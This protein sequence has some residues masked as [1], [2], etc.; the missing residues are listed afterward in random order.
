LAADAKELRPG[1]ICPGI[2]KHL[3]GRMGDREIGIADLNRLRL[4]LIRVWS[5]VQPLVQGLR[6]IQDVWQRIVAEGVAL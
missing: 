2:R 1:A 3:A 5:A 6:L 4:G